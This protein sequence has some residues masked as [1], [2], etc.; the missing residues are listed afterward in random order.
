MHDVVQDIDNI[1]IPNF[2]VLEGR[3]QAPPTSPGFPF[4][5]VGRV[6]DVK[7]A[8]L[9][10]HFIS[11]GQIMDVCDPHNHFGSVVPEL[12]TR[13][14]LLLNAVLAASALHLSRTTGYDPM[15]A[16]MYHERC[17]E[18]LIPLLDDP[19]RVADEVV[20]ATVLLRF[21]EQV[22][23]AITGSDCERHLSGTSAF[24]NS[25]STCATAGGLR[26]ASFWIFIR[27]D[28]DV[29]LG[30]QRPLK[31]NLEAYSVEID[32]DT[33]SDDWGWANCMVWITAETVA[34]TF[35]WEKSRMKY[36]ELKHRTEAWWQR[37]PDSF[38]PLYIGHEGAAFPTAWYMGPLYGKQYVFNC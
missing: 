26:Q 36:E 32:M 8:F 16:E 4:D 20:A 15:V 24:M 25:E 23:S 18:L 10:R 2:Q 1:S 13:S 35:G 33:P 37:K 31:L 17:V 21:F 27:Q 3:L 38:R 30:H 19:S 29:A 34:F 22:S 12:A 9:L 7:E 14:G 28:L 11:L 6:S 5:E